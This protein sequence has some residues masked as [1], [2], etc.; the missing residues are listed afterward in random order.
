MY[1]MALACS[2]Q[3]GR[4]GNYKFSWHDLRALTD[5]LE[6]VNFVLYFC[7]G[8]FSIQANYLAWVDLSI[9]IGIFLL[10]F[11]LILRY[12]AY[13]YMA[14]TGICHHFLHTVTCLELMQMQDGFCDYTINTKQVIKLIPV[15]LLAEFF[16]VLLN[17]ISQE[18]I[19]LVSLIALCSL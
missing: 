7:F 12:F 5:V 4:Q 6:Q 18:S 8:L 19:I 17:N 15:L 16:T 9:S 14:I 13:S 10:D 1:L 2:Y 3:Q 11:V